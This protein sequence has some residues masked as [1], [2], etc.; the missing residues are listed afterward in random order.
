MDIGKSFTYVLDDPQWIMKVLI[1]GVLLLIPI[2]NLAVFGYALNTSK[3]VADGNP[4]PMP[5]WSDFGNHFMRGLYAFIGVL[6]YFLPAILLY[7]CLF[8]IIF[9]LSLAAGGTTSRSN[10]ALGGVVSIVSLCFY[11]VIGLYS[12]VASISIPAA[13]TRFAMSANQLS[14]FWDFRGNFG[15]IRQNLSNY[16][17][18][19]LV[20]W[21]ASFVAGFGII[22]CIVG[23]VFT[24]FW[25]YMVTAYLYGQLWRASQGTMPAPAMA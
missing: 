17:I 16:V 3:N 8:V 20:G 5:E 12:L 4:T 22:L 9:A 25:A 2:V 21:V 19:L 11:C 1:G 7:C 13:L 18:A 14:I 6:V 15:F 24:W 10:D 23:V